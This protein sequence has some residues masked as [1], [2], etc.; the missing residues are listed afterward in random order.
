[1]QDRTINSV[2][3]AVRRKG[4]PQADLAEKL[5]ILRDVTL[6]QAIKP[7]YMAFERNELTRIVLDA[8]ADG[9]KRGG[10]IVAN[11]VSKRPDMPRHVLQNRLSVKLWKMKQKGR[12]RRDGVLWS[13]P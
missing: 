5:L 3:L 13:R 6:P 1:M 12:V 11:A 2:L 8:L 9:P 7:R 4:G 10:E